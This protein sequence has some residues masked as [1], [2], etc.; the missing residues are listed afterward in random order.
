MDSYKIDRIIKNAQSTGVAIEHSDTDWFWYEVSK[1]IKSDGS[2]V[3]SV[4]RIPYHGVKHILFSSEN[5]ALIAN[6]LSTYVP[7]EVNP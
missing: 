3:W 2:V 1:M 7:A 5:I 4:F 6:F